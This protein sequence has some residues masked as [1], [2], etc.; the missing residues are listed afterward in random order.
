MEF[1]KLREMPRH[2]EI[3]P[4]SHPEIPRDVKLTIDLLLS[5]AIR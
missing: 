5:D 3:H 2:P 1:K 4:E